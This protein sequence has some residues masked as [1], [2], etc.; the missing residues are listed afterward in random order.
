MADV[1]RCKVCDEP[2]HDDE[3]WPIGD[4]YYFQK[5]NGKIQLAESIVLHQPMFPVHQSCIEA[6]HGR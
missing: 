5:I 3:G 6:L 1:I 2:V 4:V